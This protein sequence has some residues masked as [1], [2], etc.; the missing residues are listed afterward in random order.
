MVSHHLKYIW[1]L[2]FVAFP[3][4]AAGLELIAPRM[5]VFL[6]ECTSFFSNPDEYANQL[7][8]QR[9]NDPGA[10]TLS[11]DGKSLIVHKEVGD[12]AIE[13]EVLKL[14][15]REIRYC[16]YSAEQFLTTE[17]SEIATQ[18]SDWISQNPN[19]EVIGGFHEASFESQTNH[20]ILGLLPQFDAVVD[21]NI[22][23]G[24]FWVHS[25]YT[26]LK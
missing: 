24:I 8:A 21:S 23:E 10:V 11:A 18:F 20:A 26:I 2:S 14:A 19:L 9:S 13:A 6:S 15:D 4:N 3:L 16:E 7:S 12:Y 25:T 17:V 5:S 1:L 22:Y